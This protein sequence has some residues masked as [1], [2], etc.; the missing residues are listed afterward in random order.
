MNLTPTVEGLNL[1]DT[2]KFQY[3]QTSFEEFGP[4]TELMFFTPV[5]IETG[6]IGAITLFSKVV[7][8]DKEISAPKL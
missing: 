2:S 6:A 7:V 8:F 3:Q 1:F 4:D 5:L